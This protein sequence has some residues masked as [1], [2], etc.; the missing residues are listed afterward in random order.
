MIPIKWVVVSCASI[1]DEET[2]HEFN[3]KEFA[4]SAYRA[5]ITKLRSTECSDVRLYCKDK[6]GYMNCMKSW[7]HCK[8]GSINETDRLTELA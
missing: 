2:E 8:G 4:M 6:Q 1:S 5:Q 7:I 3:T